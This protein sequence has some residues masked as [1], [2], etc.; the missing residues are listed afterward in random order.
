MEFLDPLLQF[1]FKAFTSIVFI[2]LVMSGDNAIIIGMAAAGL[3]AAHRRKAIAI[4]I[5]AATVLR[6]LFA[7]VTYQ[8]L[9]IIGLTLAGGL[10]LLWVA[11]KM[12]QEIRAGSLEMPDPEAEGT[13]EGKTL[14]SAVISII[15]ADV[16]M[17]LDNV[18]AVAGAAHDAPGMLVFGLVLSILLM[19]FAANW[20]ASLLE[21]HKWLAYAG[22]IVVAYVAVEMIWRGGNQVATAAAGML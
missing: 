21:K 6:I 11:Y 12:W 10:L 5:I 4:G 7:S 19:A 13:G 17:S 2:D 18:L 15:I 1:N 8:L 3:P 14:R 20:V 16:T 9:S 22:L